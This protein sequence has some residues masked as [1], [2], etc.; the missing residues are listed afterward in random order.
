MRQ[1]I[2]SFTECS[3]FGCCVDGQERW[4]EVSDFEWAMKLLVDPQLA[5]TWRALVGSG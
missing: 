3:V 2:R 4:V 5:Q 1:Y